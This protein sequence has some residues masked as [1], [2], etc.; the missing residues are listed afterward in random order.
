MLTIVCS[1]QA[2]FV[3]LLASDDQKSLKVVMS[4]ALDVVVGTGSGRLLG[5]RGAASAALIPVP[6]VAA[7]LWVLRSGRPRVSEA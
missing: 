2:H 5:A 6:F 3:F 1:L 4:D 7:D